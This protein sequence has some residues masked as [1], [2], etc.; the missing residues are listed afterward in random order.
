M[1][2]T[3]PRDLIFTLPYTGHDRALRPSIQ[4]L[5]P[6]DIA[7]VEVTVGRHQKPPARAGPTG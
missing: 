5:A 7:T 4:G 1:A 2:V 6:G 3:R